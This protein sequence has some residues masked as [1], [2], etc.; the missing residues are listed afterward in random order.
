MPQQHR[1]LVINFY[2]F[3]MKKIIQLS[4]LSLALICMSYSF[5]SYAQSDEY[6]E[7]FKAKKYAEIEK[8]ANSKLAS[9]PN[10][11]SALVAKINVILSSNADSRFDEAQK[12]A[13]QCIKT[14]PSNSE[15]HES[16]GSILGTNAMRKGV[17][18]SLGSAGTIRDSFKKAIELDPKNY[19]ARNSLLQFYLQ[20]PGIAGGSNSKARDLISDTQKVN[21]AI[22]TILQARYDIYKEDFS[23]AQNSL[24]ALKT[25]EQ[26]EAFKM[27]RGTLIQIS[28]KLIAEKEYAN[29]QKLLLELDKRYPNN[30]GVNYAFGRLYQEQGNNKDA[31]GYFEKAN[32]IEANAYTFHRLAKAYA[33]LNDKVKAIQNL[34]K[35]LQFSPSLDKTELSNAQ[36]LLKQLKS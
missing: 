6:E 17:M 33:A 18:S 3:P 36:N 30:L 7:L 32:T 9:N 21:P 15:C 25:A 24:L 8:L 11:A 1:P 23:K 4:G 34:E 19:S 14:N 10:L 29:A 2:L 16:L 26:D 13:E 28:N 12:I 20:A 22:A 5:N 27:Q 35:A 31:L